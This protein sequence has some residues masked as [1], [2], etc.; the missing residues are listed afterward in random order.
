[1]TIEDTGASIT[2]DEL[3]SLFCYFPQVE[4]AYNWQ[5]DC[6]GLGLSIIERLITLMG[7]AIW[8]EPE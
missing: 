7:G 5:L 4:E 8:V 2:K 3:P 6:T 1:M